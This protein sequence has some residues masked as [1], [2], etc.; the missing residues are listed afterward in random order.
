MAI[1]M[2]SILCAAHTSQVDAFSAALP[3]STAL[4][5]MGAIVFCRR[6]ITMGEA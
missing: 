4:V 5:G 2:I 3:E 1:K 6:C